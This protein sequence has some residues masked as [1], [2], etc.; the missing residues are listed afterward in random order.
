MFGGFTAAAGAMY[1]NACSNAFTDM[2]HL[3]QDTNDQDNLKACLIAGAIGLSFLGAEGIVAAYG[4]YKG[5]T[6]LSNQYKVDKRSGFILQGNHTMVT[7][8]NN[9]H[10][11]YAGPATDYITY[12]LQID[13]AQHVANV[14]QAGA[15][16]NN[17]TG[18]MMHT[19]WYFSVMIGDHHH[20]VIAD[21]DGLDS[22]VET[23]GRY[24]G[25][26]TVK[27]REASASK[28]GVVKRDA[29][30]FWQTYTTWAADT[31]YVN[32]MDA[33]GEWPAAAQAMYAQLDG[34]D[35]SSQTQPCTTSYYCYGATSKYC[36][37]TGFS[38]KQEQMTLK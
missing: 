3:T 24:G 36:L 4:A 18:D 37:T 30:G 1:V 26:G 16:F 7:V 12:V 29:T 31:G 20:H 11:S 19:G 2:V 15:I 6:Y 38:N 22:A 32:D 17:Q 5:W 27:R 8:R 35:F 33:W 34:G 10:L 21:E 25:N 28:G 23:L 13:A 9:T 14:T